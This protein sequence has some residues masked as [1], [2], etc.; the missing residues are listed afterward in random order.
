M[1]TKI[2]DL[3][4]EDLCGMLGVAVLTFLAL[5]AGKMLWQKWRGR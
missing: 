4:V 2:V 3:T 5:E 1:R